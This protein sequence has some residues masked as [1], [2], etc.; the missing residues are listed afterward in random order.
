M[1]ELIGSCVNCGKEVYCRDGFLDGTYV[2]SE[3]F[4]S[5]CAKELEEK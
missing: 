4:C 2:N 3:L 1:I 5:D